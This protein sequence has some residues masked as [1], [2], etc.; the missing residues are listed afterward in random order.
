MD[1]DLIEAGQNAAATIGIQWRQVPMDSRW[2]EVPAEGKNSRN[3]AGRIK[4]FPDGE[5]GHVWNHITGENTIFWARRETELEPA[6]KEARRKRA[7]ELRRQAEAERKQAAKAAAE[8]A[9]ALWQAAERENGNPYRTRK[10]VEAVPSLRQIDSQAAAV[11]LGYVPKVGGEEMT[12]P[13]LVVPVKVGGNWSSCQLI[14]SDGRKYFLPGG[15]LKAGFWATGRLPE[16][17]GAGLTILIAEGVATALSCHAA[18]RHLA[19]AALSCRNL[20]AVTATLREK[21]PAAKLIV[22]SDK[23]NGEADARRAVAESGT[24]LAIPQLEAGSDFNDLHT[25]AGL[26][27]VRRQIEAAALPGI[28]TSEEEPSADGILAKLRKGGDL[29][30][31][32]VRVEWV[33]SPLIPAGAVILFF[34]RGGLGKSTLAIQ[35]AGA[36][37]S[38]S[39]V[40]GVPAAKRPV[41]Y[42]D[43]E[44]SLAVLSERL[45]NIAADEVLFLDS[46]QSPPRLDRAE[47]F[48]YLD[49]LKALPGAVFIF[50]TLRSSQGGDENDSQAMTEVMLFLRQIRDAGGTVIFLHHTPKSSDRQFKGS[51]AIFDMTDHVLALYAVR[52]P[53][54]EKEVEDDDEDE[55]KVYR[56]GT[57]LK[58]RYE[59]TRQFLTFDSETRQFV[60]APDPTEELTQRVAVAIAAIASREKV[61]NQSRI[62][63]ELKQDGGEIVSDKKIRATLARG[64]GRHWHEERGLHNA[65]LYSLADRFGCFAPLRGAKNCQTEID[66]FGAEEKQSTH[67]PQQTGFNAEFGSFSGGTD[68]PAKQPHVEDEAGLVDFDF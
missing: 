13:L 50:D 10:Q 42:I 53:G 8:K 40:F 4:L 58:T 61:A 20:P 43:Y 15:V 68:K 55:V 29:K 21:Y 9:A 35:I 47:R 26:K 22:C 28:T 51:G 25:Q 41:I 14:A 52:R 27:E 12:G 16:G 36:I 31:L 32:D 65:K 49:L 66:H 30:A 60:V 23:G 64:T 11:V 48:Q 38:G 56:F 3:G 7:E 33:V 6:E 39:Y 59:P 17:K 5:G 62:I 54:D 37:A 34:G 24:L 1:A 18:T 2:H 44:N 63:E 45:R 46:T 57:A 19:V 67:Q